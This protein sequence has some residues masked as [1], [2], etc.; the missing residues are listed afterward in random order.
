VLKALLNLNQPTTLFEKRRHDR[1][2]TI[3]DANLVFKF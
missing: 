3:F 1:D 2:V